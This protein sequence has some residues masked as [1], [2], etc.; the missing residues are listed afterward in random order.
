VLQDFLSSNRSAL[1]DRCRAKAA[2]RS[3]PKLPSP[4]LAHGIPI[5]LDQI[6]KILAIEQS[7][8][9]LHR[10]PEPAHVKNGPDGDVGATA[11]LHGRDLLDEGFTLEQVIREYGDVCQ[12]V[13][14]L[15]SETGAPIS[16]KEFHTFNRCLDD[17]IVAAVTEY[18]QRKS[19]ASA[20]NASSAIRALEPGADGMGHLETALT[21]F[22]L[23]L[24]STEEALTTAQLQAR[25]ANTRSLHDSLTGLP[26]RELFDDRLSKAMSLAD[27]HD[28][29]VAVMFL[30]LDQFKSINDIYGHAAGDEVL[31]TMAERLLERARDEDTVCRNGGDE[32][33]YLLMNPGGQENLVRIA[34]SVSLGIAQP[35]SLGGFEVVI[36]A[37]VGIAVYPGDG[38]GCNELVT[39]AD[40]AMYR[41]KK[42]PSGVVLFGQEEGL[43]QIR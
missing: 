15:A 17:A 12:A 43:D 30:D 39:N 11:M 27:R 35:I 36:K 38:A 40:A 8:D 19:V 5:F 2:R 21:Q 26:N 13:T 9:P 3:G 37:S 33:L 28:W 24:A 16:A 22:Q 20:E 10:R 29:T 42:H 31:K 6:I 41:A 32:F 23:A 25:E 18:T 7:R 1:I 14:S 34:E 4:E